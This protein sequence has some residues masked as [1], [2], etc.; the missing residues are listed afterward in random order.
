[1]PRPSGREANEM[2]QVRLEP[3]YAKYA[4]GSCLAAF[5]ETRV[6]CCATVEEKVPPFLRNSGRG[7]VTAEYGMLP[8]S[9]HTRTDRE[10]ARG[11]QSGRTHEIQRLIGRSL[12]AVTDFAALGERQ[13]RIDCDV[14]QADGGTRTAAITGSYVALYLA[15]KKLVESGAL[16][17]LPLSDAVAAVSC[18]IVGGQAVLDLDY[19]EDSG[20]EADANFVFTGKGG[21]IEVQA[22]AE[23]TA[24]AEP[25]FMEMLA[26]GRHGVEALVRR[27]REALGIA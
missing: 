9:T 21:I 4:E 5:G 25:R 19:V 6:L 15:M 11:K 1:M 12:R 7:W 18:G 10:A 20:A 16:P 17:A 13:V 8:R 27:Q 23:K 26:L 24:F 22:T 2:R 3:G 14:L